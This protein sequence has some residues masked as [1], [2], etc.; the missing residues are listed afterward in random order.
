M[1]NQKILCIGTNNSITDL[2]VSK[3]SQTYKTINHG[4]ITDHNFIPEEIGYYHTTTVDIPVGTHVELGKR[5]DKVILL[6]QS[7]DQ[8][9]HWK[10]LLSSY[11]IMQE[12]SN[13]GVSTDYKYNKN[14]EHISY[15][16][17]LVQKNKSFC[18]YP[19]V[20]LQQEDVNVTACPKNRQKITTITE[21]GDWQTN[22]DFTAIRNDMLKGNKVKGCEQCYYEE[23]VGVVSTRQFETLDWVGKLELKNVEDLKNLTEPKYY[24]IRLGNTCNMAC[25]MCIPEYSNIIDKEFKELNILQ[26]KTGYQEEGYSNTKHIDIEKLDKGS[27]VYFTG[28]EPTVHEEFYSFMERCIEVGRTDFDFCLGYNG[29]RLTKKMLD[30]FSHFSNMN[31]S[32]SI[33]GYGKINDY[34]RSYSDWDTIISNAK[35][36]RAH[37]HTISMETIPSIYNANNLHL[38]LEFFDREFP[39]SVQF[40]QLEQQHPG[41]YLSAYAHPDPISCVESLEKVKKTQKYLTDGRGGRSI[42]DSLL[43]HYY[44]NPKPDLV[45][46]KSFYNFN[47]K[48]DK[49][50]ST[51]LKDYLPELDAGRQFLK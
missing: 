6:D 38:L 25:R 5:F 20:L 1:F 35:T 17:N 10:M 50:R 31:F 12:L 40:L 39:E 42:I 47:D 43:N 18:I 24:E 15:F 48:L 49:K 46:L 8:W 34:I 26:F 2:E 32:F 36:L 28:G 9:S 37:G 22:K 11:K 51:L 19:W 13:L 41:G 3:R 14:I 21:V 29:K 44:K 4:L 30:M 33:D 45:K 16:E 27:R 7:L 23:R